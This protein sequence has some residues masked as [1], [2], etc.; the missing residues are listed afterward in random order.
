M[1]ELL[2]KAAVSSRPES[3]KFKRLAMFIGLVLA[4]MI[5]ALIE[6]LLRN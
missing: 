3:D 6:R 4:A 5:S 2:D 1:K